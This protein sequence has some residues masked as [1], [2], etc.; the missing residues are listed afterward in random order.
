VCVVNSHVPTL[1]LSSLS[2]FVCI[3]HLS[4]SAI[5]YLTRVY[6]QPICLSLSIACT[7]SCAMWAVALGC[8]GHGGD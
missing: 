3:S 1:S 2:R 6:S 8:R 7:I 5:L 4:S